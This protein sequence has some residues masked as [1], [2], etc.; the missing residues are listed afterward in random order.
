MTEPARGLNIPIFTTDQSGPSYYGF[1][2][3]Y[4]FER[5]TDLTTI[6]KSLPEGT[7]V[8]SSM[9]VAGIDHLEFVLRQA[10]EYWA[11]GYFLARNRSIDL[12]MRITCQRQI[13][14]ALEVSG[15]R[16]ISEVA[17]YGLSRGEASVS[18]S[19]EMLT[20]LGAIRNDAKLE[21]NPQKL[22]F[23]KKFHQLPEWVPRDRLA[24]ILQEKALGLV[25]E[26]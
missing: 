15:V 20:E 2:R 18:S 6:S 12:L 5:P 26:K 13:S 3:G 4:L 22:S 23:L 19:E 24:L 14:R 25:F 16:E 7:A 10:A 1:G 21:L 17:V 9:F 11:R 8:C